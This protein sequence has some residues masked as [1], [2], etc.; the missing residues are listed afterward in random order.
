MDHSR[1]MTSKPAKPPKVVDH[2][3]VSPKM[4]GGV[5]VAHH[6]TS[7]EHEPK[8]HSFNADQG[9]EF[10]QHMA[11]HAGM[12]MAAEPADGAAGGEGAEEETE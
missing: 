8:N 12:P 7:Y 5:N 1:G 3:R 10:H 9:A 2:L 4:G 6:Y 11:T